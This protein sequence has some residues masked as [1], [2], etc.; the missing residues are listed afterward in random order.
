MKVNRKLLK[1]LY[2]IDHTSCHE[3]AMKSFILNYCYKI[4]KLQFQLDDYGNLF[5]TKN[6]SNPDLYVCIIAHTDGVNDFKAARELTID[7]SGTIK[8]RYIHNHIQC[9][10]NADDSNGILVALQLL[11][12]VPNLK[13]CFTV[14]EELGALGAD[15][16]I[17]NVEF[18]SNVKCFIQAD[19]RGNSDLIVHTNGIQSA[20]EEFVNDI[21]NLSKKYQYYENYG[22]FTDVGILAEAY[23]ISGVNISCGYKN[24]HTSREE[25]NVFDLEAC[26]NYIYDIVNQIADNGKIYKITVPKYNSYWKNDKTTKEEYEQLWNHPNEFDDDLPCNTCRTFDCMHCKYGVY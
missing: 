13:V 24:E 18:F 3:G 16:A 5:I 15:Q 10:L 23:E 7:S 11:E 22:T 25:S 8:A 6:T 17:D 21:A 14:Q 19:R 1:R 4:P 9:G 2:L 26:L 12:T 20:S